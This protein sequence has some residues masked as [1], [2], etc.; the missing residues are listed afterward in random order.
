MI[1]SSHSIQVRHSILLL[2]HLLFTFWSIDYGSFQWSR[3]KLRK[4]RKEEIIKPN[5]SLLNHL[6][7]IPL[8]KTSIRVMKI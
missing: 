7:P 4:R 5:Y 3:K 1:S 8:K 2:S 6:I